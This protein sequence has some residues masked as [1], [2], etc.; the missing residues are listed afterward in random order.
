VLPPDLDPSLPN[1]AQALD[2]A[3]VAT[4]FE[5]DWPGPGDPPPVSECV[6]EYLYWSP[7]AEL[8]ATYRLTLSSP[9]ARATSAFRVVSVRPDG[10]LHR[11]FTADPGLPGLGAATDPATIGSWLA[12][13]LER[14]IDVCAV[15]PVRYRPD[16]RCVL[17]YEVRSD[18]DILVLYGKLLTGDGVEA[19]AAALTALGDSL[20]APLVGA[21]PEWQLI[22]QSDTGGNSLRSVAAAA[23]GDNELPDVRA[24]ARLLAR[25]HAGEG[26]RTR[27]RSL[28]ED[29]DELRRFL[30]ACELLSPGV[31][32]R[33]RQGIDR[34]RAYAE[35]PGPTV[36]SHGAFRLD[37]VHLTATGPVLIDLD[38]YCCAERER[39]IGNLFAYLRW[40]GIRRPALVRPLADVRAAFISGYESQSVASIDDSR[41]Q[42]FEALS[43]LKI[44]G[45]RYPRLKVHEWERVPELIAAAFEDLD[46]VAGET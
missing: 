32:A 46:S 34:L 5:R 14:P 35:S 38:S 13:R 1:L 44:A 3:E 41:V 4:R 6:Q 33:L 24:G 43:L 2:P 20:T 7:G 30:P 11:S 22:V 27:C 9:V 16:R 36:P 39:D 8:M 40:R 19:L 25:V 31:A 42:A 29:A 15:T 37:Q 26:P 23:A 10:V 12:E 18:D 21:A 45:R 17:R 28:R